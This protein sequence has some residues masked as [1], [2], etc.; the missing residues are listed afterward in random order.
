MAHTLTFSCF[1]SPQAL[2]GKLQSAF[3][4]YSLLYYDVIV[5]GWTIR[6]SQRCGMFGRGRVQFLVTLSPE[7][8]ETTVITV[9]AADW[10][11][12]SESKVAE[13]LWILRS[14]LGDVLG[15]K[16]AAF[17]HDG[18]IFEELAGMP[19]EPFETVYARLLDA[20]KI[21]PKDRLALGLAI[22]KH[23]R[24][25]R[26]ELYGAVR[27]NQDCT[28]EDPEWPHF[29][30]NL[31][32]DF[33]VFQ[34]ARKQAVERSDLE[35]FTEAVLSNQR[36]DLYTE[37]RALLYLINRVPVYD[38]YMFERVSREIAA[39]IS[40]GD[41]VEPMLRPASKKTSTIDDDDVMVLSELIYGQGS[42]QGALVSEHEALYLLEIASLAGKLPTSD[43]W[44]PFFKQAM[45]N[46]LILNNTPPETYPPEKQRWVAEKLIPLKNL[47]VVAQ[48]LAALEREV[49]SLQ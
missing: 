44:P 42:A 24:V 4:S 46:F 9:A 21:T 20:K 13:W 15:A 32:G 34:H 31:V 12:V 26:E 6:L 22:Y 23:D 49:A 25:S 11:L 39:F 41:D 35:A 3:L 40:S 30:V 14:R 38:E 5:D 36:L 16:K 19:A 10:V 45:L 18:K 28:I 17:S 43:E 27:L 33:F 1:G 2:I 7:D 8:A 37:T 47:P 48:A 29:F